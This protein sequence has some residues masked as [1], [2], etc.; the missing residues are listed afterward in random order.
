MK[1]TILVIEDELDMRYL[2]RTHLSAEFIVE[3][4]ENGEQGMLLIEKVKPALV[5]LDIMMPGMD[6]YEVCR[7]IRED[8]HDLPILMLTAKSDVKEKI[9]GLTIGAD[10]Y[11]TKPFDPEEL[12]ARIHALLRR[13]LKNDE[14]PIHEEGIIKLPELTIDLHAREVFVHQK[15]AELTM[16]EFELLY[17]LASSPKWAF[18]R[19]MLLDRIWGTDEVLEIRTVDSHV[20]HIRDKLK[21]AN[22]SYNPIKTV[23]GVGYKFNDPDA[24]S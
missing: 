2:L 7:K 6:G 20:K 18:T 5:L 16:K 23:W 12:V 3:E 10:D 21:Q 24:S 4:A 1:E 17:H 15:L 14:Q 8:H 19:E 9:H 11:V 22:L 13:S